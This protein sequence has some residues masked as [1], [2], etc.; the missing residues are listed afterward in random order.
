MKTPEEIVLSNSKNFNQSKSPQEQIG[1]IKA[2]QQDAIYDL[3]L[4]YTGLVTELEEVTGKKCESRT[5]QGKALFAMK[6]AISDSAKRIESLEQQ[7]TFANDAATKGDLARQNAG[8]MELR[9]QELEAA[10]LDMSAAL[11]GGLKFISDSPTSLKSIEAM[12]V[13]RDA[14]SRTPAQCLERWVEFVKQI[15]RY[16]PPLNAYDF[17]LVKQEAQQL[18]S[19]IGEK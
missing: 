15:Q 4:A 3:Q 12:E 10:I 9:I 1:F 2:I 6:Q 17:G 7:L 19:S 8:D 11:N 5:E 13:M 16:E 18:L 14:L